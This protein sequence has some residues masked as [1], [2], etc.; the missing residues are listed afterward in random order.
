MTSFPVHPSLLSTLVYPVIN[1]VSSLTEVNVSCPATLLCLTT[2]FPLP[3]ISWQKEGEEVML[4]MDGRISTFSFDVGSGSSSFE[5]S[6][7]TGNGSIEGLIESMTEF[8]TRDLHSLGELGVVSLL[9]FDQLVREDTANYTCT[10]TNMLPQT[11]T[12]TA[13]SPSIP[14]IVLGKL[15]EHYLLLYNSVKD[16]ILLKIGVTHSGTHSAT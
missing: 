14:L 12:L 11:T 1:N 4:T 2:G 13:L 15:V 3:S 16:C 6:G 5:S 9:S 8:N 10:A 7:F